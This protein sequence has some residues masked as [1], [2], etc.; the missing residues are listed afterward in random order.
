MP[1]VKTMGHF[2]YIECD[3][4]NCSRKIEHVTTKDLFRLATICGWRETKTDGSVAH[5]LCPNCSTTHQ[6]KKVKKL[7]R[8]RKA[9]PR[10]RT[11]AIQSLL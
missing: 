4:R 2:N 1:V 11:T 9:K 8:S 10:T 5:W 7:S 6:T 3:D